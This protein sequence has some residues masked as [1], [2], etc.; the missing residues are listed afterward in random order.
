MVKQRCRAFITNG[1][2]CHSPV[3]KRVAR[4]YDMAGWRFDN[5]LAFIGENG[6]SQA[7]TLT[8]W[9]PPSEDSRVL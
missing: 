7:I 5:V 1:E 2:Q 8:D 6:S 4:A 3:D 9:W